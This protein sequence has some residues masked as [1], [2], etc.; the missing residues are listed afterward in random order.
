MD[1]RATL[2]AIAARF[3][4]HEVAGVFRANAVPATHRPASDGSQ[5]C[6][7]LAKQ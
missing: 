3:V 1:L 5:K 2:E 7:E 6:A 4:D